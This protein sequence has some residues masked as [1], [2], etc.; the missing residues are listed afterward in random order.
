MEWI[1]LRRKELGI[2]QE[3]LA[4][5]LQLLGHDISRGSVGH[6]ETGH[7]K[8]QMDNPELVMAL[9]RALELDVN[10]VLRKSGYD[11]AGEHSHIA[12]R[13]AALIDQLPADKQELALRLVE[14]IART[15]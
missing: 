13:V 10:T 9:S 8:P 4:K 3:E 5:R 1:K 14:Q 7:A 12:E 11:I 2:S 6:W 15:G